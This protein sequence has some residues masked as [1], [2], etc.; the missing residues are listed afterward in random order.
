MTKIWFVTG[1]SRGLG[2]EIVRAALD[3]G[4][5]VVATARNT[6]DLK[7][8]VASYGDAVCTL[9][10]DVTDGSAAKAAISKA[11][12]ASGRLDVVVNNAGYANVNSI[13]DL[14]EDDFRAQFET[15]FFGVYNVTR[16]ALPIMRAQRSGL[17]IQ[18]SSVGGR[19][20]SPGVG[21]YQA[22]KWAVGGFSEVL[23]AEV[24]P[25]GIKVTVIEPGGM[26]T[27][28]AGSSMRVDALREEYAQTVG[29]LA[30]HREDLKTNA[31]SDPAKV[32]AL[33]VRIAA[34]ANPPVRLLA[35]SD[36][37]YMAQHFAQAR[38]AEDERWKA[39]TDSTD[40]DGR[41]NFAESAIAQSFGAPESSA[42]EVDALGARDMLFQKRRKEH[43][44]VH[45]HLARNTASHHNPTSS[46]ALRA[47]NDDTRAISGTARQSS[48]TWSAS[49]SR[50]A[51]A[52]R[53]IMRR[54]G[55][56][57]GRA[58]SKS[59]YQWALTPTSSATSSRRSPR[60][61]RAP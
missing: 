51:S 52:T 11:V 28:W 48:F 55:R 30:R 37:G 23:A 56:R 57:R 5:R 45:H 59:V 21:S 29:V 38:A 26:S 34:E 13:E 61:R 40:A 35:G 10:L 1:S 54:L 60:H 4:D 44:F 9:E 46:S 39:A 49:S 36:A 18:I 12:E 6:S 7:S 47:A 32:A 43:G 33:V 20:A 8:F 16:A 53:S 3:S 19:V 27:D 41:G 14:P 2:R 31:Q 15:N 17:I 22:A 25:L 42:N 58:I 50:R 24:G